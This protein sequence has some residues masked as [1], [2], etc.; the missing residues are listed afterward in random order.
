MTKT[1]SQEEI[2]G[3]IINDP[4]TNDRLDNSQQGRVQLCNFRNA[5]QMSERYARFVTALFEVFARSTANSLG[6]YFT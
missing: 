2:D 1:L 4:S 3:T 6:A 5:G